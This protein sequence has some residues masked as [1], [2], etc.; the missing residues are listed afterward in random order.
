[1]EDHATPPQGYEESPPPPPDTDSSP[2]P[3]PRAS[4]ELPPSHHSA[5]SS[6]ST[7]SSAADQE[8]AS[9]SGGHTAS[10]RVAQDADPTPTNTLDSPL[11]QQPPPPLPS[12]TLPSSPQ[13]QCTTATRLTHYFPPGFTLPPAKR[14]AGRRALWIPDSFS[15]RCLV[16]EC[17]TPLKKGK[18]H[19]CRA[20]GRNICSKCS[21]KAEVPQYR[22]K[23]VRCCKMCKIPNTPTL[24][25][26]DVYESLLSSWA[27]VTVV[28][29]EGTEEKHRWH[30]RLL[31]PSYD[32]GP[33]VA[34]CSSPD[35]DKDYKPEHWIPVHNACNIEQVG[36]EIKL[37]SFLT[38]FNVRLRIEP[39]SDTALW[40][41]YLEA[42][43]CAQ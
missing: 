28:S 7:H 8:P 39:L 20:C 34:M 12:P 21:M 16:R 33:A 14:L 5:A 15:P 26:P 13:H 19:H 3:S 27:S 37:S 1:M 9:S 22:N 32:L 4:Y 18:R 29:E 10:T 23:K 6:A 17:D 38:H 43:K 31:H 41:Q 25:F 36:E 11:F 30:C 24:N 2:D 42:A 40:L 35:E